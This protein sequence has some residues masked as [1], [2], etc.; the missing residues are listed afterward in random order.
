MSAAVPS[1]PRSL[2]LAKGLADAVLALVYPEVCDLCHHRRAGPTQGYVCDDC[3]LEVNLIKPPFC[4]RCG[5][6]FSG[7]IRQAFDCSDC[8]ASPPPFTR[9]R[10]VAEARGKLLEAIHRYKYD[11]GLWFEPFLARLF[12][13]GAARE[14]QRE[15]W[16]LHVPVPLFPA[17]Q[18]ERGFNQA[19][20]LARALS[21]AT[22][23]PLDSAI[24]RRRIPTPSQ[25]RLSKDERRKNVNRAFAVRLPDRAEGRRIVLVDD[26][27][28]T[29]ATTGACAGALLKAGAAEVCVWTVAR[30]I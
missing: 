28:T 27:F 16:D 22:G 9:A 21:R 15:S 1:R 13:E 6:P 10:S 2:A 5:K 20:Q 23:I 3:R 30:G 26:V 17:K 18:R 12:I 4:N 19:E 24:L 11:A 14:L 25:T 8:R 7:D 29:G